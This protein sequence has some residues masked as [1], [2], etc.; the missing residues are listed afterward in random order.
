[1]APP[2]VGTPLSDANVVLLMRGRMIWFNEEKGFGFIRT[3]DGERLYVDRTG[4]EP[5]GPPV[6]RCAEKPVS[7]LREA[8]DV[9]GGYRAVHVSLSDEQTAGGRARRRRQMH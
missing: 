2:R 4:F 6:G 5:D 3:D 7:F 8:A 1:M 9:E